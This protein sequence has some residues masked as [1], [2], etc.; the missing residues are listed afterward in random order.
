MN[1]GLMDNE[2]KLAK[3]DLCG[4]KAYVI[5][6]HDDRP[7]EALCQYCLEMSAESRQEM[8]RTKREHERM[9]H[10]AVKEASKE[11]TQWSSDK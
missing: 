3:C 11:T 1:D 10:E 8:Y 4:K 5:T 2:L 9:W 6:W 7:R